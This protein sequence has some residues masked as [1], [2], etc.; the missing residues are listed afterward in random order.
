MQLMLSLTTALA[1]AVLARAGAAHEGHRHPVPAARSGYAFPIA[2]PGTYALPPIKPAAGGHVLDESARRHDLAGLLRAKAT[3]L[4]FIYTRCG[5]VCPTATLNLARIQD[6]AA[7]DASLAKRLRLVSMS[8]DPQHD[9]PD[10]MREQ[11]AY[12]RSPNRNA[13]EWLFLTGPDEDTLAPVLAAYSQPVSR[14]PDPSSPGGPLHHVFR[15]FLIDDEGVIRNIYSL[16]F[17]DP[18]LVLN[19]VRTLLME[20]RALPAHRPLR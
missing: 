7:N 4:V 3:V 18:D 12:W 19:D 2:N 11:A 8:F 15:A 16:D 1:L 10:V 14:K 20:R 6:L 9:T 13:P 17:F 5:D